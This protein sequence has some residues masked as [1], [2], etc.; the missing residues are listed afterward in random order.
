MTS[1]VKDASLADCSE[2]LWNIAEALKE[3]DALTTKR[4]YDI[5]IRAFI[6]HGSSTTNMIGV[7]QVLD[8]M[9]ALNWP[10]AELTVRNCLVGHKDGTHALS[11]S[12]FIEFLDDSW[13][14]LLSHTLSTTSALEFQT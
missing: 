3:L 4:K 12:Q 11:K 7:S 9:K 1:K 10:S 5:F 2:E 6:G 13:S 8:C 14:K